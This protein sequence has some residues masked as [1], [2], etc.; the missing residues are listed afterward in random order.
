[1]RRPNEHSDVFSE[2]IT[3]TPLTLSFVLL[4]H[5]MPVR[6]KSINIYNEP[7]FF[8]V[9]HSLITPFMSQKLRNRVSCFALYF[10]DKCHMFKESLHLG[11]T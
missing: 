3:L 5:G 11:D 6:V 9:M 10:F 4:Q 8:D 1:M 2:V 7:T